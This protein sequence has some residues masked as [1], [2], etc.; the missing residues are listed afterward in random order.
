MC[1]SCW[2][3]PFKQRYQGRLWKESQG[4]CYPV[5]SDTL[6][7]AEE[8]W[9]CWVRSC[10]VPHYYQWT[11]YN[12]VQTCTVML[13]STPYCCV[14]YHTTPPQT[15]PHGYAPYIPD[16][17]NPHCMSSVTVLYSVHGVV[18]LITLWLKFEVVYSG[19]QLSPV[20]FS[21]LKSTSL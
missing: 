8:A 6:L 3:I 16:H 20:E 15:K 10:Y 11:S 9:M 5:A 2:S 14:L 18:A 17:A 4:F 12:T 1:Q 13:S 21:Y 7:I 19:V